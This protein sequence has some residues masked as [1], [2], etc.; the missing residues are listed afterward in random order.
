MTADPPM[1]PAHPMYRWRDLANTAGALTLARLPLAVVFVF[2]EDRIAMLAVYG[3]GLL[4]DV[5]D[6]I[7]ARRW[8]QRSDAGAIAD[9]VCDKTFHGVVALTLALRLELVPLWWLPLW[10]S[11]EIIQL[12]ALPFFLKRVETNPEIE[13]HANVLGKATSTAL[14]MACVSAMLGWKALAL[15]LTVTTGLLGLLSAIGYLR[16]ERPR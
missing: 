10:F 4:T 12:L 11:R 2:L 1:L 14:S 5:L 16:R 8:G 6:G 9:G 13:R 3:A 7:V 15:G